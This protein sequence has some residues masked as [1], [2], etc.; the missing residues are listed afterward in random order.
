MFPLVVNVSVVE[1]NGTFDTYDVK[2][3]FKKL[4]LVGN[5]IINGP[6]YADSVDIYGNYE[7][8]DI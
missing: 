1:M 7:N 8:N 5:G 3:Q 4:L 2:A 6:L